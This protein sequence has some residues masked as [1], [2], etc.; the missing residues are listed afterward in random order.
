MW[1]NRRP[2][3]ERTPRSD[4][5]TFAHGQFRV[6]YEHRPDPYEL[7]ERR[8]ERARAE[9][10]SLRRHGSHQFARY[11]LGKPPSPDDPPER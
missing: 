6:D 5:G 7:R 4:L 8:V 11:A 3:A 9:L 10:R 1:L 2:M